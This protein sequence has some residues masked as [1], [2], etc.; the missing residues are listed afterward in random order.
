ML[1]LPHQRRWF[2]FAGFVIWLCSELDL[3]ENECSFVKKRLIYPYDLVERVTEQAIVQTQL[4][5]GCLAVRDK[6]LLRAG[7]A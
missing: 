1:P 2:V 4:K 5:A 7:N 6:K 3:G